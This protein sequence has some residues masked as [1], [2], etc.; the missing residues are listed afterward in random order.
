[1]ENAETLLQKIE[2]IKTFYEPKRVFNI[3]YF[4]NLEKDEFFKRFIKI[5]LVSDL[6]ILVFLA[7][8][9][10]GIY[11]INAQDNHF[12]EYNLGENYILDL[13]YNSKEGVFVLGMK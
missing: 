2:K 5:K 13:D 10:L 3:D 8:N 11:S 4:N 6:N 9:Q 12:S 1:M 7:E